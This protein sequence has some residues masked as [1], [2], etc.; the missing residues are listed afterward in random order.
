[1]QHCRMRLTS[2]ELMSQFAMTTVST[3]MRPQ[4]CRVWCIGWARDASLRFAVLCMPPGAFWR[5]K[6]GTRAR[7]PCQLDVIE[8][9]SS[10][11]SSCP[12]GSRCSWAIR[13]NVPIS[14]KQQT[15]APFEV[16]KE[17]KIKSC[18]LHMSTKW[19]QKLWFMMPS[20]YHVQKVSEEAYGQRTQLL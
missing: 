5:I 20:W 1:M 15:K 2:Q 19:F 13:E 14:S 11:L 7:N 8:H 12:L 10:C 6:D 16:L 18:T 9:H 3:G 17:E 4:P